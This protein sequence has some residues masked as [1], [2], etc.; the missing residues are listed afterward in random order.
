M[1]AYDLEI[2]PQPADRHAAENYGWVFGLPPGIS[3]LQWPLDPMTGYPLMHGFTLKLPDDMRVH[4]PDIV[5]LSFFATAPEQSDGGAGAA[6]QAAVLGQGD[7]PTDKALLVFW[8]AAK[9]AHPRLFRLNDILGAAYAVILLTAEDFAGP[10]CL[11]PQLGSNQYLEQANPPEWL[12]NGAAYQTAAASSFQCRAAGLEGVS[13]MGDLAFD[14]AIK[15]TPRTA[16]PNAGHE[17]REYYG[18]GP[19]T[20]YQ[21]HYYWLDGKIEAENYRVHGWAADHKDNHI[22]GTMRPIQA[23]PAFS[24]YYIGFEE[25]FGGYNFGGGN[26]QLDFKTMKVDW[27]CG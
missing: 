24:P 5:A 2:L 11:P 9:T 4:G 13:S 25:Y 23:M 6:L 1:Q 3:P 20:G 22:G 21:P 10:L 14:R 26:A 18:R 27:A 17:P 7:E 16:D 15:C 19:N 12:A 8:R